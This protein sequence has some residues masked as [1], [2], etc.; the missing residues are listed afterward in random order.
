MPR[1]AVV[2]AGISGLAAAHRLLELKKNE[3]RDLEVL[4]IEQSPRTGGI[5]ETERKDGFLLEKGPDAFISE[6]PWAL[7][8]AKRL[9]L[10]SEIIGTN[11]AGR[12][13]FVVLNKK[14][15]PLPQGFYLIAPYRLLPFLKSPLFSLSAKVRILLEA[16]VPGKKEGADESVGAFI[17]RRFGREAL[18]R[19]GQAM[20]AGIY[21]GDPE[22][23]SLSA[24]FPR[25]SEL[26]K[27]YGSVI[28][29]LRR[30]SAEDA[31]KALKESQGPRYSLFCSFKEGMQTLTDKIAQRIPGACLRLNAPVHEISFDAPE[32]KWRLVMKNGATESADAVCVTLPA[33]PMASI[34]RKAA[35]EISRELDEIHY[36]SV[37]TLHLAFKKESVTHP[38]DGFG[39]VVP[40]VEMSPVVACSFSSAKFAERAPQG[41]VLIRAFVGGAF[42]KQY[43]ELT[44]QALFEVVFKDLSV[45]L[46]LEDGPLFWRLCR[47]PNSMVQY[48]LNHLERVKRMR[49]HSK[50][51]SGLFLS[52]AV[53][54]GV[55]IPDCVYDAESQAEEIYKQQMSLRG[56]TQ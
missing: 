15:V 17:R 30:E 49:E 18:E 10:E 55:G 36:E 21:T 29:G 32:K 47:T 48:G 11:P 51:N 37:A 1:V 41:L 19:V 45:F 40:R 43:L 44:D 28:R 34:L 46:G 4:L 33:K 25:F 42:G 53:F 31:K 13:S 2:G 52:G 24:A 14:L 54:R 56:G 8:L 22:I 26:E 9:G 35:P 38:M 23:L 7:D 27:K 12:K 3:G 50:K 39:F 16:L 20:L 6:K 5:I